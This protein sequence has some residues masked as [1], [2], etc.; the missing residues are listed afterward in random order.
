MLASMQKVVQ[1]LS[2]EPSKDL[3]AKRLEGLVKSDV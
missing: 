2:F 1:G 3:R